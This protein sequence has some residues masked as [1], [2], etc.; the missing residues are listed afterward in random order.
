MT[1]TLILTRGSDND[2]I[3]RAGAVDAGIVRL[4]TITWFMP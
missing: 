3:Y 4:D 1:Q 2:A